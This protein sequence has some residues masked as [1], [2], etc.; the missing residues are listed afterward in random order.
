[1]LRSGARLA[2][3]LITM[4]L[5]FGLTA[6]S[7]FAD[8]VEAFVRAVDGFDEHALLG[9]SRCHGWTRLDVVV[10]TIGGW[11][12]MLGGMVSVV[13]DETTVGVPHSEALGDLRRGVRGLRIAF[14]ETVFF[15]GVD[16][17]VDKAVRQ[18]RP[19][20]TKADSRE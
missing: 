12:E 19:T 1:M 10:H 3:T 17:E 6:G 14:G 5:M 7:A 16:A 20:G 9:A 11:Q 2:A 15:D 8:S 18:A 4:A 13:D